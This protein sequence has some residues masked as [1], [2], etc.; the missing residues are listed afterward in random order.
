MK[1][2]NRP[3]FNQD[4]G[5]R[6]AKLVKSVLAGDQEAF[7]RLVEAYE[8][9]AVATAYRLLGNNHDA[10]EVVQ[11][12]FL[13]AFSSLDRLKKPSRFGPWLIRIVSNLSLNYRRSRR[14]RPTV[15]LDEQQGPE[16]MV[17]DD[18]RPVATS[19]GPSQLLEG[20]ELQEAIDKVL[21]SL[22]DKQRLSLVMFAVEG[23]AQKDIADVL[24]CSVENVKWNVFQARKKLREQ[25][26][27]MI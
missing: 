12:A 5:R 10:M 2:S 26:G 21:E 3:L 19:M 11:E 16:T 24:E 22:P 9:P 13:R 1:R 15:A 18:A 4:A 7:E 25:L 6:D 17:S 14:S 8:R 20:R 23:W 27:H